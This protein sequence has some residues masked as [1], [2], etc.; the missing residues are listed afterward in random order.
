MLNTFWSKLCVMLPFAEHTQRWMFCHGALLWSLLHVLE[1]PIQSCKQP[2]EDQNSLF[3]VS[4]STSHSARVKKHPSSEISCLQTIAGPCARPWQVGNLSFQ[5]A[6]GRYK[7]KAGKEVLTGLSAKS[8]MILM[9]KCIPWVVHS[10]EHSSK[11]GQDSCEDL[12]LSS[13]LKLCLQLHA[14]CWQPEHPSAAWGR[15]SQ[16][17][18]LGSNDRPLLGHGIY[19]FLK[20]RLPPLSALGAVELL[21]YPRPWGSLWITCSLENKV[22]AGKLSPPRR[23]LEVLCFIDTLF[24]FIL[25]MKSPKGAESTWVLPTA[26]CTSEIIH[27]MT[28]PFSGLLTTT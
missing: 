23:L 22:E 19:L 6:V 14:A 7:K 16:C 4:S 18:H 28:V 12:C 17:W 11:A 1:T 3:C 2:D 25:S 13:R 24:S 20:T 9:S 5:S 8:D 26:E 21:C 27:S 15:E 10:W